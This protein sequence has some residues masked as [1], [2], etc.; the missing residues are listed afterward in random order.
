MGGVRDFDIGNN[1][2][3]DRIGQFTS[4]TNALPSDFWNDSDDSDS[5]QERQQTADEIA[6]QWKLQESRI[7]DDDDS[8]DLDADG[9]N[10]AAFH[11]TPSGSV[12]PPPS[13]SQSTKTL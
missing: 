5:A 10:L 7:A 9:A 6:A 8:S 2:K 12:P 11:P 13:Y 1:A 4:N 3:Y